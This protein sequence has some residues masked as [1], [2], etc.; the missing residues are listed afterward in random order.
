MLPGTHPA[1]F[2]AGFVDALKPARWL[3]LGFQVQGEQRGAPAYD[4]RLLLSVWLYGCFS[5]VLS[6][7]K[8]ETACQ[9]SIPYIW[10]AGAQ[11]PDHNT[12]WR[13]YNEHRGKI[14][15]LLKTTVRT[16]ADLGVFDP[17]V[18]ALDGTKLA[19]SASVGRSYGADQLK[20]MLER[21]DQLLEELERQNR[22]EPEVR[23]ELPRELTDAGV[24]RARIRAALDQAEAQGGKGIVNLTDPE[25]GTMKG[26]QGYVTG[27]NAQALV[28]PIPEEHLGQPG[29]FITAAGITNEPEDHGQLVPM[30]EAA[31]DMGVTPEVVLADAGYHSGANLEACAERGQRVL[32]PESSPDRVLEDPFHKDRFTYDEATDTYRCPVGQVLEHQAT[33]RRP[34]GRRVKVYRAGVVCRSC[35][36]FGTCTKDSRK[37]RTLSIAPHDRWLREHRAVM[38]T[39]EAK[40]L[41]A[42]RQVLVE[43]VFGI[44]KEQHGIRRLRVRGLAKAQA[45]WNF[46]ALGFN[47]RQ[48]HRIWSRQSEGSAWSFVPLA[49]EGA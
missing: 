11:R 34:G 3:E 22:E 14:A 36:F 2:I 10:L 1:R 20:R 8:L 28:A 19:G 24:L 23:P 26:R 47:L 16:A 4:P 49:G 7:R 12:L 21:V 15:A 40:A 25:A 31:A 18:Q 29:L 41:Y 9:E 13:F 42:R 5:D 35:P 48:L 43:P 38:R 30:L 46:I 33:K 17:T 27:F 45:A 39:E 37:G 44:L 6:A 32:M